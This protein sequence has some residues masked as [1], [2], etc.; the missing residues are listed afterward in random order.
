MYE[1][2][3]E[4]ENWK[5]LYILYYLINSHN[6]LSDIKNFQN[7]LD[8]SNLVRLTESNVIINDIIENEN[9]EIE[10][11]KNNIKLSGKW[12]EEIKDI[13]DN[14][15]CISAA[16]IDNQIE[17]ITRQRL[18]QTWFMEN[19]D[20]LEKGKS[21]DNET[22]QEIKNF[23][24]FQDNINFVSKIEDFVERQRKEINTI[25]Y[26]W[27]D[28]GIYTIITGKRGIGKTSFVYELMKVL[29]HGGNLGKWEVFDPVSVLYIDGE[30]RWKDNLDRIKTHRIRKDNPNLYIRVSSEDDERDNIISNM[31]NQIFRD[32]IEKSCIDNEIKVLIL[33]NKSSLTP[34]IDE[35]VKKDWDT[36][37]QWLLRLR[38][39]GI[40]VILITHQGWKGD[41]PRGTS[42][43]E[44][45]NDV[46]IKL[47][48]TN[49]WKIE[50]GVKFQLVFDKLRQR[51]DNDNLMNNT[52]L[53]FFRDNQGNYT[54]NINDNKKDNEIRDI[55]Y[56][57]HIGKTQNEISKIMNKSV[58]W[59][60]WRKTDLIHKGYI[61]KNKTL[62]DKGKHLI[63]DL[64]EED[65]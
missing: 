49:D 65:N 25:L 20:L 9:Q 11:I 43:L 42:S 6:Y 12:N 29:T 14:L 61:E 58:G 36:I 7:K 3:I 8:L 27:L 54:W 55:L 28:E 64:L 22:L 38:G 19:V 48:K 13:F 47:N 34:G 16:G 39:K 59:V 53:S 33:D 2:E 35:N 40:S 30:M 15:E 23:N 26:P 4:K 50:N 63:Q 44:D 56:Y 5:D 52:I 62:T 46:S 37:N 17:K 18:Y 51:I 24:L 31:G 1:I 60:S 21:P 10:Q 57:F 41:N 45:N 32:M